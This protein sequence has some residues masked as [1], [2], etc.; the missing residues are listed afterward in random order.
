MEIVSVKELKLEEIEDLVEL[1]LAEGYLFLERLV[2]EWISGENR[3]NKGNENLYQIKID[4]KVIGIGGINKNPY[5]D[6][7]KNGRIRH[8][9]IHPKYRRKGIGTELIKTILRNQDYEKI[10]LRTDKEEASKFYESIGFIRIKDSITDT[11][12]IVLKY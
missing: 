8:F 9:Y 4:G 12:E 11:H 3:F 10:T 7:E 6:D 2:N 1:S 5:T